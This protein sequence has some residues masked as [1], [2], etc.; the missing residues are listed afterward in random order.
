MDF[1]GDLVRKSSHKFDSITAQ[2]DIAEM[3]REEKQKEIGQ[4]SLWWDPEHMVQLKIQ[5][6]Q[7]ETYQLSFKRISN[8]ENHELLLF[9]TLV[10][11]CK[12]LRNSILIVYIS[13][14]LKEWVGCVLA[15]YKTLHLFSVM[16]VFSTDIFI[17]VIV[18]KKL[19]SIFF[20]VTI[21]LSSS[22]WHVLSFTPCTWTTFS[23][24]ANLYDGT[25][26]WVEYLYSD[27]QQ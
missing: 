8:R 14:V 4:K 25:R 17:A 27:S 2:F 9:C 6:P 20:Y 23:N 10:T 18:R 22:L 3:W 7:V 16:Y 1:W 13:A 5:G 26:F 15:V 12:R 24:H 19:E 21:Q 11:S